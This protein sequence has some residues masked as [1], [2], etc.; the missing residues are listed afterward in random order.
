MDKNVKAWSEIMKKQ[1]VKEKKRAD[2]FDGPAW[3][4]PYMLYC[5]LVVLLFI[6]LLGMAYMAIENDWIPSRGVGK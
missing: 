2:E 1:N 6:F 3:K 5:L 4:H